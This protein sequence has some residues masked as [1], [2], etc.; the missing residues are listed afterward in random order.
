ML[1]CAGDTASDIEFRAHCLAGLADL[2]LDRHPTLFNRNPGAGNLATEPFGKFFDKLKTHFTTGAPAAGNNHFSLIQ[3]HLAFGLAHHLKHLGRSD[4]RGFR[5][6]NQMVNNLSLTPFTLTRLHNP[7][8]HRRHLRPGV[9]ARN[10]RHNIAAE[11]RPGLQQNLLIGINFK[12][13][14][15][16]GQPRLEPPRQ[17]G[18]KF[19]AP[20][21]GPDQQ[22]IGFIFGHQLSHNLGI[23]FHSISCKSFIFGQT[24]LGR[25]ETG[26]RR[27]QTRD[28][29]ARQNNPDL[30]PQSSRQLLRLAQKFQ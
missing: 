5:N 14:A 26:Q 13:R 6:L 27:G 15:I 23:D 29:P 11:S 8:P 9:A 1:N 20:G 19:T 7:G 28:I 25:A 3:S 10:C 24:D 12:H 17:P 30:L 16:C 21:S 18:R 2:A 22:D 4:R